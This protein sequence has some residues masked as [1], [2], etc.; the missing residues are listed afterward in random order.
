MAIEVIVSLVSG[1][2]AVICCLISSFIASGKAISYIEK[3]II[4]PEE[5]IIIIAQSCRRAQAERY[6][7]LI[8]EKFNPK[9]IYM[10]EMFPPCG[11][12]VGPGLM[13]AYYVGKPIS[14]GAEEE[15]SLVAELLKAK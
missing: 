2:V 3:T 15:K 10:C 1:G 6:K 9:K 5:Q 14:D 8:Q 12:N 11:I 13:A 4:N 7:Q